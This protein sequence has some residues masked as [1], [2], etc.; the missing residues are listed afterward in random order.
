MLIDTH[1]HLDDSSFDNDREAIIRRAFDSGLNYIIS[2]GS[3]IPSSRRTIDLAEQ[4]DNIYATVGLHPHEAK[5]WDDRIYEELK[6]LSQSS[7]KVVAVGEMGLDYHYDNSPRNVQ[8]EAFRQEIRLSREIG[9]PIVVHT[10]EAEEDTMAILTEEKASEVG[11]VMHCFSSS[12]ELALR[13]LDMG[14]YISLAGIVTFPKATELQNLVTELPLDCILVETDCPYL[15][16]IP[17][18]GKRNEPAY[19]R[20]TAEKVAQ[21]KGLTPAEVAKVTSGNAKRL[22]K[23]GT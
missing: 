16:P 6:K 5:K 15:T 7:R 12:R 21:L 2:I 22:F 1:A 13:C 9:L 4:Y 18:R 23:V 20:H 3:D 17:H 14:F 19:V 10:R 11:G 8:Q